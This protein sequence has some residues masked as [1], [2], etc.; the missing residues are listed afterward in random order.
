MTEDLRSPLDAVQEF[1]DSMP[2]PLAESLLFKAGIMMGFKFGPHDTGRSAVNIAEY[3]APRKGVNAL[4]QLLQLRSLIDYSLWSMTDPARRD[5]LD[6]VD[7]GIIKKHP[8]AFELVKRIGLNKDEIY[9]MADK[10][11][12]EWDYLKLAD[13]S[14]SYLEYYTSHLPRPKPPFL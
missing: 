8:E 14:Y 12:K 5:S 10:A 7:A 4:G 6:S 11:V 9:I 2:D 13:L 1:I 3:F